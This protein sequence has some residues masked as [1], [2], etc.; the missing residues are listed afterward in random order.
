MTKKPRRTRNQKLKTAERK[1]TGFSIKKEW[2]GDTKKDQSVTKE[3]KV[4]KGHFQSD[5]TKTFVL[6]MLVLALELALWHYLT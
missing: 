5:L 3:V 2:L 4:D 1:E 6:T